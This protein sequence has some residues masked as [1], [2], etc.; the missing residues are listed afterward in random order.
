MH[1]CSTL[2]FIIV[3]FSC[4]TTTKIVR[5]HG[6]CYVTALSIDNSMNDTSKVKFIKST[7]FNGS[8]TLIHGYIVEKNSQQPI[9]NAHVAILSIKRS[10]ETRTNN[11]GEFEIFTNLGAGSWN[12]YVKHDDYICIYVIDIIKADGQWI[13]VKLERK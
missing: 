1:K 3:F 6:E 4:S 5:D 8:A 11:Q 9:G 10:I 2:L 13:Y 12:L 7:V